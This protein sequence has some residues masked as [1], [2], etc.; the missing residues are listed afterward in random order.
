MVGWAFSTEVVDSDVVVAAT[1]VEVA[2][3]VEVAAVVLVDPVTSAHQDSAQ[4]RAACASLE[5]QAALAQ[6]VMP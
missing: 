3:A 1:L 5:E 6:S 2:S 4:V